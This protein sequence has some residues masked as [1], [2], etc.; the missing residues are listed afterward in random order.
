MTHQK[1]NKRTGRI[2]LTVL[3]LGLIGGVFA[4]S[5]M[6][7]AEKPLTA[8]SCPLSHVETWRGLLS[9]LAKSSHWRRW[10]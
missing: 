4:L 3:G 1:T 9:R 8:P 2:V 10:K 7:K 6:L 5:T